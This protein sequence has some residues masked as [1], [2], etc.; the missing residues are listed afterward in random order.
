M[1]MAITGVAVVAPAAA[2]ALRDV[3]KLSI[4][5]SSSFCTQGT[6]PPHLM[7]R[8]S[9]IRSKVTRVVAVRPA[10]SHEADPGAEEQCSARR[11]VLAGLLAVG[12]ALAASTTT[13]EAYA[14]SGPG[15]DGAKETA[16]KASDL[17]KAGDD[18]NV[19]EAPSRVG[20]GRIEDAAKSAKSIAQQAGAG[21][22]ANPSG[23][24]DDAVT[25]AREK[26]NEGK[27]RFGDLF[28]EK[29]GSTSDIGD[30]ASNLAGDA[31]NLANKAVSGA[32]DKV[33]F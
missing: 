22:G 1:A 12:A 25:K 27:A 26:L 33:R 30:K 14:I 20:P 28:K 13:R 31:K 4:S 17:L 18:L 10:A 16:D 24:A 15:G 29:V 6:T 23:I 32:Q 3:S 2:V 19:N 8:A 5:S 11:E 9:G 7:I 21:S